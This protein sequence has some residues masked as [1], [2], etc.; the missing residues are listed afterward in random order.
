[1]LSPHRGCWFTLTL[2]MEQNVSQKYWSPLTRPHDGTTQKTIIWTFTALS[3]SKHVWT[4]HISSLVKLEC[5]GIAEH[6]KHNVFFL[7]FRS[8][9]NNYNTPH[10]MW[11]QHRCHSYCRA[12]ILYSLQSLPF[13]GC[14]I[15]L[16]IVY[17]RL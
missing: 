4:F 5:H 9:W 16:L 8:N 2:K 11:I 15:F 17:Q 13:L 6:K 14:Q 7:G 10:R 1:M 12:A 3:T